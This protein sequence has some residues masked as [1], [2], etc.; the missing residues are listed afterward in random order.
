M[1]LHSFFYFKK[2]KSVVS[3]A[4]NGR[5]KKQDEEKIKNK[6]MG[7]YLTCKSLGKKIVIAPDYT[8][9]LERDKKNRKF[10]NI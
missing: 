8:K 4:P 2:L 9:P 7:L 6:K 3:A 5:S 10:L 1:L